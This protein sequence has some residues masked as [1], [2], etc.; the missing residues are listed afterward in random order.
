LQLKLQLTI[1]NLFSYSYY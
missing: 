1:P